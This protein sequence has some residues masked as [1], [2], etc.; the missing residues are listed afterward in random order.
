[1]RNVEIHI[2]YIGQ[3]CC[4]WEPSEEQFVVNKQSS[5]SVKNLFS[6]P[7]M[8]SN[9]MLV[10]SVNIEKMKYVNSQFRQS[11]VINFIPPT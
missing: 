1:M 4:F 8:W 9:G 11:V 5:H 10:H 7:K 6:H 2:A 3:L